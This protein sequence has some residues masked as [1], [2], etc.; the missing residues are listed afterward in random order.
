MTSAESRYNLPRLEKLRTEVEREG[1]RGKH[2]QSSWGRF[3][4]SVSKKFSWGGDEYAAVGRRAMMAPACRSS[5]CA[6][7]WTVLNEGGQM[8]FEGSSAELVLTKKGE[9]EDIQKHAAALLGLDYVEAS[10]L[11][12]AS[13]STEQTLYNIDELICAAKHG[14]TWSDQRRLNGTTDYRRKGPMVGAVPSE[15]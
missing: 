3:W 11:F 6:A 9:V 10:R 4:G 14:R 5:A 7:G 12:S 2:N 13:P 8:L 15:A 1:Q